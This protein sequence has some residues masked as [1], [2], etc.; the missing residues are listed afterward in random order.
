MSER[1]DSTD[2]HLWIIVII[3]AI[4]LVSLAWADFSQI[5]DLQRRVGQLESAAPKQ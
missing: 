3:M 2:Y 1:R 5:R 4:A